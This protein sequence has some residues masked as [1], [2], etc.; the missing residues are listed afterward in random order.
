MIEGKRLESI[1]TSQISECKR[2]YKDKVES[3]FQCGDLRQA[4]RGIKTMAGASSRAPSSSLPIPSQCQNAADFS[5]Q[6]NS[7]FAR[8]EGDFSSELATVTQELKRMAQ[9]SDAEIRDNRL[10]FQDPYRHL[11]TVAYS[12]LAKLRK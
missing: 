7:H 12:Q 1:L 6:L 5:N 9:P 8:F 3:Q 2:Q 11:R 4:W 10:N